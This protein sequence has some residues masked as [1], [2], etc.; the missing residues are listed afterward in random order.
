MPNTAFI[1]EMW[2]SQGQDLGVWGHCD[3]WPLVIKINSITSLSG[4]LRWICR[5]SDKLVLRCCIQKAEMC[6]GQSLWP[7]TFDLLPPRSNQFTPETKW[8][9]V[10]S[11][12]QR[13]K[14]QVLTKWTWAQ[15]DNRASLMWCAGAL[16]APRGTTEAKQAGQKVHSVLECPLDSI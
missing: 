15:G 1:L 3:L 5:R 4:H 7:L 9:F 12:V 6:C 14:D 10:L 2:Y 8:K 13:R 16:E 11:P